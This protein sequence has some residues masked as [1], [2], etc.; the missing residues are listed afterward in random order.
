M[1][2]SPGLNE[3][4]EE[5]EAAAMFPEDGKLAAS[6]GAKYTLTFIATPLSR[7]QGF[8]RESVTR[9][10]CVIQ[11]CTVPGTGSAI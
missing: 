4:E 11:Y 2:S 5:E 8:R 9:T 1:T 10:Y 6:A 3:G 7:S